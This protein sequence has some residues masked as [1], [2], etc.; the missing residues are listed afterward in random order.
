MALK[1]KQNQFQKQCS[2]SLA[3]KS[4]ILT[5]ELQDENTFHFHR[6]NETNSSEQRS[7]SLKALFRLG[8]TLSFSLAS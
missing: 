5:S 4:I 6:W 2:V 3:M 1:E 7:P 8:Q